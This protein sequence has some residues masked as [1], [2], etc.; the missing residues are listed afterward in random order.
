M[1]KRYDEFAAI[2][3]LFVGALLTV[4]ILPTAL[5]AAFDSPQDVRS[6]EDAQRK[7]KLEERVGRVYWVRP[8]TNGRRQFVT[9]ADVPGGHSWNG[10]RV[11]SAQRFKV[12]EL[13][14]GVGAYLGNYLVQFDDGT[15]KWLSSTDFAIHTY[16]PA[17]V[18]ADPT[19][20]EIFE[21]DPAI[22]E[23]RAE[24]REKQ[25]RAAQRAAQ[26]AHAA[27]PGVSI[28]MTKDEVLSSRWGKPQYINSTHT[29]AGTTE[30][31]VYGDGNY[32]YFRNGRLEAVQN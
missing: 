24:A 10:S 1:F 27:K 3:A 17:S 6:R 12:V 16:E 8:P 21:E 26:R 15:Q 18:I 13:V 31:W 20:S 2:R 29:T 32:L 4:I 5:A 23:R 30:Q 14:A 19:R 28:G 25:Q 22:I 7:A 9:F 11:T